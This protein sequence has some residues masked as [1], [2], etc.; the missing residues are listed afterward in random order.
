MDK[1]NKVVIQFWLNQRVIVA[2]SQGIF[3]IVFGTSVASQ[4]RIATKLPI[5]ASQS[6]TT[7]TK[8]NL[9]L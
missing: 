3:S 1:R 8:P 9:H 5:A 4:L 7:R 6:G 2:K